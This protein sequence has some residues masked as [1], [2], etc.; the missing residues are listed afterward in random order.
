MKPENAKEVKGQ[1]IDNICE[2]DGK[3]LANVSWLR[4]WPKNPRVVEE[5]D[6]SRLK[7]Q[8]VELGVYKPL[9]ITPDGEVLGGNQR[10]KVLSELSKQDEKYQWIWVSIVEAWTD[11]DRIKYALSDNDNVGKYTREKMHE[12]LKPFLEQESLFA[13]YKLEFADKKS[14]DNFID[15]LA[16]TERELELKE[17]TRRLKELGIN[18]ETINI[19]ND[20]VGFNKSENKIDDVNM[21]GEVVN[22]RYPLCFWEAD[23]ESYELLKNF[24]KTIH[25][26]VYDTEKLK[27]ILEKGEYLNFRKE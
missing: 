8:I 14:I 25:K 5:K 23:L 11:Q 20:M 24:F 2:L 1:D 27:E 17:A 26:D 12:I 19:I 21:K 3:I 7:K 22:E 15:E 16:M 13:D 18:E 10:F 9:V 6:L 4:L